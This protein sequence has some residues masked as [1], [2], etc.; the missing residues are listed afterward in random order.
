MLQLKKCLIKFFSYKNKNSLFNIKSKNYFLYAVYCLINSLGVNFLTNSYHDNV[1]IATSYIAGMMCIFLLLHETWTKNIKKYLVAYWY[2]T[3]LYTLPLYSMFMVLNT[4]CSRFS[5]INFSLSVFIL[6][7]LVDWV[8]FFYLVLI[9]VLLAVGLYIISNGAH[10]K[11]L[12]LMNGFLE[13]I[14]MIIMI[15]SI[16][17][18]FLKKQQKLCIK[19]LLNMR[20]LASGIAH[21]I[22]TPLASLM[23]NINSLKKNN[24]QNSSRVINEICFNITQ[25]HHIMNVSVLGRR[26]C[27]NTQVSL[28]FQG[29]SSAIFLWL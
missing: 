3:L 5:I 17:Y 4:S 29:R 15:I 23:C 14:Y 11:N 13:V 9:G 6:M 10:I 12:F 28:R 7:T 19:K 25:C 2:I 22:R 20:L 26:Y 27:K 18:V 1:S 8:K 16:A 24:K 21:E